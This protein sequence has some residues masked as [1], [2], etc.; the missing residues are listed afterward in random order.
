MKIRRG[1]FGGAA[2]FA[3]VGCTNVQTQVPDNGV[4]IVATDTGKVDTAAPDTGVVDTGVADT[5]SS[6]VPGSVDTAMPDI[7]VADTSTTKDMQVGQDTIPEDSG[8]DDVVTAID[9]LLK[10]TIKADAVMIKDAAKADACALLSAQD[11][12]DQ[13]CDTTM[14]AICEPE[15]PNTVALLCYDGT[16]TKISELENMF[17]FGCSCIPSEDA[18]TYAFAACAVPG[19]VGLDRLGRPRVASISLRARF[20]A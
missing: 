8:S 19:F 7:F 12:A 17:P 15:S 14:T 10:D 18:C 4:E 16:W 20:F 6:D 9:A 5:G 3:A 13:P 1:I 11:A 2:L